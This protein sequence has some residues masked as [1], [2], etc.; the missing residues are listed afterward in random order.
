MAD[1]IQT[2]SNL[3]G[4]L[5][6]LVGI[7]G[8]GV[9]IWGAYMYMA[10]SGSPQQMERGK[11]TMFSAVAGVVLVLSAFTVT[12]LVINAIVGPTAGVTPLLPNPATPVP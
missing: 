6:L 7:V 2:I 4:Y 8:T 3:V 11:T 5:M 1:I 10:A 9:F 12:N